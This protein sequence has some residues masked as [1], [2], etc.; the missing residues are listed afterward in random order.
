MIRGV[1]RTVRYARS[2]SRG[3]DVVL[4][5]IEISRAGVSLPATLILP[6]NHRGDLPGWI[7]LG[8][9]SRMGRFH[10]QLM[11]FAQALS[12]SGAAVLVPEIPEWR[13]LT[14]VPSVTS[15]TVRG[16]VEALRA[17]PEVSPT[18][19][20][21]IGFSFGAPQAVIA[22]AEP[23]LAKEIAG[24][25]LF[26][27]YCCLERTLVCQ[28]TGEHHWQGV[29]Y[30]L[31]PD[32]YGGWVVGANYLTHVTGHEDAKDVERALHRLACA[33]S[34]QRIAAW[35]PHHDAM[36]VDLR[37]GIAPGR[38][39]IFDLF[40][41]PSTVT[42]INIEARRDMAVRLAAIC[43][44]AEPLLGPGE[45]L[46]KVNVP[47]RLIHG[48][49]DRLIPFTESLRLSDALPAPSRSGLTITGLFAHS[50]DRQELRFADRFREGLIWFGALR[51]VINTT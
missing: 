45:A 44:R 41:A 24:V 8:G 51:G 35:M 30:R 3:A 27:G 28:L 49:G 2:W 37:A 23:D 4:E 20:G 9:V 46:G 33:A 47:T 48:R 26:G 29:D 16:C 34:D 25:V 32:P 31:S 7:A 36:I 18:K 1:A 43:Q 42:P 14:L 15:P 13:N 38:R 39:E 10:P 6:A 12:S 17:R 50:A 22:A 5:E 21:L 40:A 19:L 11:R